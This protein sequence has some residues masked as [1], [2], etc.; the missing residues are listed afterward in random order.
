[1]SL[2][3][4]LGLS[5]PQTILVIEDKVSFAVGLARLLEGLGHT[6]SVYAGVDRVED[7]RLF[8]LRPLTTTTLDSVELS[9]VQS[10]FL[11]HYFEGLMNGTSLTPLLVAA[12]VRVCGM[13]SVGDANA[14]MQRR[15]A[16]FAYQKDVLA[17]RLRL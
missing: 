7:G 16:V 4:D 5:Q 1:V 17:R 3:D 2:L 9:T 14:S 8:G 11:D 10:C 15:G 6:V 13:S 12:G